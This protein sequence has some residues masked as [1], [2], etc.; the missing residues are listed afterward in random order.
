MESSRSCGPAPPEAIYPDSEAGIAAIQAHAKDHGYALVRR[1]SNKTG[2]RILYVCDRE[3]KYKDK[4]KKREVN[5]QNR[6]QNTGSK[7]TGCKMRVALSKDK[8]SSKWK[9]S[10]LQEVHNHERST[11]SSAHPAYRISALPS[12]INTRINDYAKAGLTNSQ[13]VA[14]LRGEGITLTSKDVA[15]L[16]QKERTKELNGRSPIQWLLKVH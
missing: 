2:T 8:I 5:T 9:V 11:D 4:G 3:G 7:K 12:G 6:R 1:D 16:V 10:I 15:N 14:I 13:I